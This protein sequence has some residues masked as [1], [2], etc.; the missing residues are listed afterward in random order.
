MTGMY[1]FVD[2]VDMMCSDDYQERFKAEYIQLTM[3]HERLVTMLHKY[4]AGMLDFKP[5]CPIDVLK[6]QA[7]VMSEYQA[8]LEQRAVLEGIDL[9]I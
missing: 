2:T 6:K 7:D 5:A 4:E 1:T 9:D 3:R 8:V